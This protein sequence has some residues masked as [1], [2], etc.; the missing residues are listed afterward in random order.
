MRLYDVALTRSTA[1]LSAG[2]CRATAASPSTAS[3]AATV[4]WDSGCSP[5]ACGR[6]GHE[7][8]AG[9]AVSVRAVDDQSGRAG[10]YRGTVALDV[11][12]PNWPW[13]LI[14]LALDVWERCFTLRGTSAFDPEEP[15]RSP[16]GWGIA[17]N[18]GT[19]HDAGGS[20][21][22]GSA[23]TR[24]H[25]DFT[26]SLPDDAT[27]VRVF[28]GPPV[29]NLWDRVPLPDEPTVIVP[30]ANWPRTPQLAEAR[31]GAPTTLSRALS[32][33]LSSL[34]I[35]RAVR[36]ERVI[37]VS[38][39]LDDGA[40]GDLCVLTVE[41]WPRC[42][43]LLVASNGWWGGAEALDSPSVWGRHRRRA[44]VA[45]DDRGGEYW[46]Q[47]QGGHSGST[48]VLEVSFVPALDPRA[49]ALRL[50]FPSPFDD[51]GVTQTMVRLSTF[52][53]PT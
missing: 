30:V 46:G 24:W 22:H 53:T 6:D 2:T 27:E 7:H 18:N 14:V 11:A 3:P 28:A 1:A 8:Q 4:A 48:S 29:A 33:S 35:D 15:T 50:E 38:M 20:G 23:P 21:M 40:G 45:H 43:D 13:E 34:V 32:D 41:T 52:A 36:P 49:T 37:P 25:V 47:F 42:F 26:P 51:E 31:V 44:W 12:L 5:A 19:M 17:T 10:R 16:G 39:Q 9:G